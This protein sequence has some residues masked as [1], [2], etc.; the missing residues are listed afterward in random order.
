[1]VAGECVCAGHY[2]GTGTILAGPDI[3]PWTSPRTFSCMTTTN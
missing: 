1:M 2:T 3:V